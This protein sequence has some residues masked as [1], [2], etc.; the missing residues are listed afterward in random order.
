MIFD[1][2]GDSSTAHRLR[3]RR[4]LSKMRMIYAHMLEQEQ[5]LPESVLHLGDRVR[6]VARTAEAA[7][8]DGVDLESLVLDELWV[9]GAYRGPVTVGGPAVLLNAKSAE[10]MGLAIHELATNSIKFGALSQPQ[11]RLRV[12]WWFALTGSSRL[13]FEWLEDG[14]RMAAGSGRK[15]GFGSRLVTRLIVSELNGDG[16]MLFM[17]DGMACTIEIPLAEALHQ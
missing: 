17:R 14:V 3:L 2:T 1:E 4:L 12:V 11:T 9:Y 7:A 6:A 13:H 15:I 8:M 16:E 5:D 10:F